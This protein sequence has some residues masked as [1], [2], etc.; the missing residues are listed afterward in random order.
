VA[1]EEEQAGSPA[2]GL[3]SADMRHAK[4]VQLGPGLK[5][6]INV[7]RPAPG[8][9]HSM[10]SGDEGGRELPVLFAG[11]RKRL[12]GT[13][14]GT[15][16]ATAAVGLVFYLQFAGQGQSAAP[17][18]P[19]PTPDS[20]QA[21]P[22]PGSSASGIT[23]TSTAL[24]YLR[25]PTSGF[26]RPIP[27]PQVRTDQRTASAILAFLE[28]EPYYF[29]KSGPL[30]YEATMW[31]RWTTDHKSWN[32][33]IVHVP[34]RHSSSDPAVFSMAVP[35]APNGKD[36][37]FQACIQNFSIPRDKSCTNDFHYD[38]SRGRTI[39]GPG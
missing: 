24:D 13:I 18:R 39:L 7:F 27:G 34:D 29:I 33:C 11:L 10:D 25:S 8:A 9:A 28:G 23:C 22:T 38:P 32:S 20:S 14:A 5:I 16:L 35:A 2:A 37:T 26:T 6:Q 19:A 36:F 3:P 4:G 21:R 31:L 12:W 15:L 1:Q 17:K 30:R